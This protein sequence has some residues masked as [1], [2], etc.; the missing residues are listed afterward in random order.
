MKKILIPTDFS[1]NSG[2]AFA[3]ALE[4]F[5]NETVET[6]LLHMI[7]H[8]SVDQHGVS[9]DTYVMT[10]LF[11]RA[12]EKMNS[13]E[14]FGKEYLNSNGFEDFT[15]KT[16]VYLGDVIKGIRAKSEE[17][18]ADLVIVGTQGEN[19]KPIERMF[20]TVSTALTK[21]MP[22]PVLF[23][24]KGYEYKDVDN[25]IFASNLNPADP[26]KLWKAIEAIAPH[27]PLIR[28]LFVD[29][30]D[31]KVKEKEINLF[32]QYVTEYSPTIRTAFNIETGEEPTTVI[33]ECVLKYDA[34]L[35]IMQKL[36]KPLLANLFSISQTKKMVDNLTVPLLV[37]N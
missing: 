29:N 16:H 9:V 34:E 14:E 18:D 36:N 31:Q 17:L 12:Q 7:P 19:H 21:K 11:N 4:M 25:V 8:V 22:C 35:I 28:Y 24:P 33:N 5:E 13:V 27:K 2:E 10:E 30:E 26:F 15:L 20:G 37:I 1:E 23:V 6:H 3:Y 32:K